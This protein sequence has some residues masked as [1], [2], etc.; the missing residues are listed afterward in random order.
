MEEICTASC[1]AISLMEVGGDWGMPICCWWMAGSWGT[2][3]GW[4]D[5]E[6]DGDGADPG[7]DERAFPVF[8]WA[9]NSSAWWRLSLN[10]LWV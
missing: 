4:V 5:T 3:V 8:Q 6:A 1:I 7:W 9:W 2:A 10:L